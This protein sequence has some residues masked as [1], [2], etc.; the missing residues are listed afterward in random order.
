MF[1]SLV[2][3][4]FYTLSTKQISI[5][6]KMIHFSPKRLIQ[7]KRIVFEPNVYQTI[8][9]QPNFNTVTKMVVFL[10]NYRTRRSAAIETINPDHCF[11]L[12]SMER[13]VRFSYSFAF[14]DGLD[15]NDFDEGMFHDF[16][17]KRTLGFK[18]VPADSNIPDHS[19]IYF[20][21]N[22]SIFETYK[23]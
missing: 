20:H 9:V 16:Y 11:Y 3:I 22:G 14:H 13:I 8:V 12:Q 4:V 21:N 23:I 18:L 2:A 7:Y 15:R 10:N 19:E 17:I 6:R 5:L 1:K